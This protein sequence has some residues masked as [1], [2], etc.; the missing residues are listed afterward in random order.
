MG[1]G[2]S[3]AITAMVLDKLLNFRTVNKMGWGRLQLQGFSCTTCQLCATSIHAA[4]EGRRL[5][6]TPISRGG[7]VPAPPVGA[8]LPLLGVNGDGVQET[9]L[10]KE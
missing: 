9:R 1:S 4:E 7:D 6:Q 3:S 10:Q 5:S 8:H 2:D